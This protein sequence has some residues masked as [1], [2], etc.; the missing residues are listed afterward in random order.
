MGS[1]DSRPVHFEETKNVI[2]EKLDNFRIEREYWTT[3]LNT[4][5]KTDKESPKY[6]FENIKFPS[7]SC[8]FDIEPERMIT[9]N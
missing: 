1:P 2:L 7:G 8:N 9:L 6:T 5:K 3:H 4:A